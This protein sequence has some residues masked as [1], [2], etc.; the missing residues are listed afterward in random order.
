MARFKVVVSDQVFP[1]VD[2][3]R[4]LLRQIDAELLVSDATPAGLAALA[5][6][7]DA[8]LTTYMPID[9]A[10]M[11]RLPRCQIIARYGIGV[12]NI[13]LAAAAAA[14]ITVT[15]VP[16]YSVEE[17][18]AHTCALA[19]ALLRR[20]PEADRK[21]HAGGWGLAGLRP[22][23]RVSTLTFGL[24][25]YGK[26]GGRVGALVRTL[27]AGLLVHDPF[28]APRDDLELV[29]LD[30]LFAR[31]DV[32]SLHLPLNASSRGLAGQGRISSMRPGSYLVNTS[33]G[34]L[35]VL[36]AVLD[37]LRSGQLAGAGLDVFDPEPVDPTRLDGVP[38]LIATPHMAYYSEESL[39]ESQHKAATQVTKVLAGLAPDYPVHA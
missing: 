37:A 5:A 31:S 16:D 21:V 26:I 19:L 12:D 17:V 27:G 22:I 14:G 24:V 6:D 36:D 30:E 3:E 38:N 25:G 20:I 1:T 23:R 9:G 39:A 35:V 8:V 18:A 29:S 34:G 13:D 11:A 2:I 32:V 4:E 10:L 7:A 28:L 33:R 15:N